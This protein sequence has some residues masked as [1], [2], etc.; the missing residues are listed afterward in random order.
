MAG[1]EYPRLSIEVFGK[2]LLDS[3]DLDPIY[4][5][6]WGMKIKGAFAAGQL[7][8]WLIA[9]WCFYHAGVA[10]YLS[11]LSGGAFWQAMH[12]AAENEKPTPAPVQGRWPRGHERRHFRGGQAVRAVTDLAGTYGPM[13]ESMVFRLLAAGPRYADISARVREHRGFG[14]WIAFKVGDMLERVLCHPVEFAQGE[15][16]YDNPTEAAV[17]LWAHRHPERASQEATWP[18]REEKVL[19]SLFYLNER[20]GSQVAPPRF[21]RTL[22]LQEYET[23]LCKWKSHLS[24]HYPLN[25]DIL[26]V[27][28]GVQ[29]WALICSTARRFA[30]F[31][32][33]PLERT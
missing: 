8:R 4:C 6:L 15:V 9:Y 16:M 23:I 10:C 3:L 30:Q 28:A 19:S 17:M 1:R 26:E 22:G 33:R 11:E 12:A 27:R 25:N 24:G 13:P 20:F 29:E 18:S 32:P 2:H 14:P 7:E 31:L 5:A 21:D